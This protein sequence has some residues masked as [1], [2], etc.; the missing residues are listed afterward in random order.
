MGHRTDRDQHAAPSGIVAALACAPPINHHHPVNPVP[1]PTLH[2]HSRLT[3]A[4]YA[5]A[6]I[7]RSGRIADHT[8][9][10][11]LGWRPGDSLIATVNDATI[12]LRPSPDGTTAISPK[13][14]PV[15]P[16]ALRHRCRIHTGDQLFLIAL[17][18]R[19]L[20]LIHT[21][22]HLDTLFARH[23]RGFGDTA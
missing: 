6:R 4:L 18:H 1:L 9:T 20:L 21:L 7:D 14:H 23:E 19:D 12:T 22:R 15:L 5:L 3:T 17:P 8:T 16:A 13:R 10:A 2:P 11:A